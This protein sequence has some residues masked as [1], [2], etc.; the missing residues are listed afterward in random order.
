MK[1][2]IFS[3]ATIWMG[4]FKQGDDLHEH[5][6]EPTPEAAF[7]SYAERL[8]AAAAHAEAV[9]EVLKGKEDIEIDANVHHIGISGPSEVIEELVAKKLAEKDECDGEDD[10][11]D[12]DDCEED[13]RVRE[14]H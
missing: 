11:E 14:Q 4:Y 8:K 7:R 6:S 9:A 2:T 1:P 12:E 10:G 5:L 13:D 3:D